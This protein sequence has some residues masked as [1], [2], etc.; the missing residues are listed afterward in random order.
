M[1]VRYVKPDI[2][3]VGVIDWDRPLF[4]M[5]IPL[6]N[7][8]SYNSYLILGSEKTAL[9]DTAYPPRTEEFLNNL[10]SL[11]V[12][13]IDYIIANHGEQDHSGSIPALLELYPNA[14]VVTNAK[15]KEI[16][17]SALPIPEEK[18]TV[19][20]DNDTLSLG[21]K[22]LQFIIAPWVH[23]PDTMFTHLI[24]DKILF[25]CDFLGS[26]LATTDLFVR[27]ECEV[28]EP[29]KRYFAEIMMPFSH[30]HIKKHLQRI[31]TLDIEIIA[32]SHGPLY[33]KPEM[34]TN[35][36]AD[37]ISKDVKNEV[38]IPYVSMYE[39]TEKMVKY[40]TDKLVARGIKVSLFNLAQTDLGHL[41]VAL[42]D[43]TTV[44][45]GASMVLMGPH[46]LAVDAAVIINALRPQ[47]RF[48][49]TVGSYGWAAGVGEK[50]GD[51]LKAMMPNI[52]A[53][54]LDPVI[55]KG[56]P[57]EETYKCLD[58]LT[59]AIYNKHQEAMKA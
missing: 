56:Q 50:M 1:A 32:P 42:V 7:G 54:V 44:V 45:M 10:R 30:P 28:Y 15:C 31:S 55:T 13:E 57:T 21:N 38:I 36:Y 41:A 29:A 26:H 35:A 25:T 8:T 17:T 24:E 34:I 9:I 22:T 43:A 52:K 47:V 49:S 14:Q 11:G 12:K 53:E 48:F 20:G 33:D 27:N 6:P 18:V 3:E 51:Q 58:E 40:L 46:P 59:E 19:I 5:L 37:W 4:D 2:I 39:S 23:W 16:I